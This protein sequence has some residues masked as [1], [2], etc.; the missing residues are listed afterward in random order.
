MYSGYSTL[1]NVI[2]VINAFIYIILCM[3]PR[4]FI[5]MLLVTTYLLLISNNIL[6]GSCEQ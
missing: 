2:F 6:H 5:S 4:K 1:N 3:W